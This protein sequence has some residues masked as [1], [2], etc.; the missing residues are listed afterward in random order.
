M[1]RDVDPA[2][3]GVHDRRERLELRARA[4]DQLAVGP[5]RRRRD[6]RHRDRALRRT[7]GHHLAVD[8]L[9]VGRVDLELLARDLE[10]LLARLLGCLLDRPSRDERRARRERARADGR[11]VGVR[12]VVGDPVERHADRLG[13]DL[14]LDR[15][16]AVPDVGGTG[17]HVDAPVRLDLDPRLRRVAVLVHS[18]GVLDCRESAAGMDCHQCSGFPVWPTRCSGSRSPLRGSGVIVRYDPG[19]SCPTASAIARIVG[20]VEGSAYAI[21]FGDVSPTRFAFLSRSS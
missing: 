14:R 6:V 4:G 13:D 9:E 21:P 1:R 12:V 7:L 20:T 19:S 5:G 16:R 15:L 3:L 10:D 2:G 8:D 18:R 17:E 11:R